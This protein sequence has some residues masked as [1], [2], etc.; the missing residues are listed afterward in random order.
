MRLKNFS[1]KQ[2]LFVTLDTSHE[3]AAFYKVGYKLK[4]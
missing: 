1:T 4:L 2:I 3:N